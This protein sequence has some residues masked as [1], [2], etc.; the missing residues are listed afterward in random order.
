MS[1]LRYRVFLSLFVI[2]IGACA[3]PATHDL[4]GSLAVF[5]YSMHNDLIVEE[6]QRL[7][8]GDYFGLPE[9]ER[10]AV[11]I[12]AVGL[13]R[14]TPCTDGV[15]AFP[16]VQ[17]GTP[18]RITDAAGTVLADS[19]LSGGFVDLLPYPD[20]Q[21]N[22]LAVCRFE[23]EV[24]ELADTTEYTILIGDEEPRTFSR[25]ALEAAGWAVSLELGVNR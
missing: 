2:A 6:A 5:D 19:T 3:P 23:F 7:A 11:W 1:H 9:E 17:A 20:V 21:A 14:G 12:E 18:V 24:P 25:T 15:E 13:V 10:D 22:V 4:S 8:G 16:G